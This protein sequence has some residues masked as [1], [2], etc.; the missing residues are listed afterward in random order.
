[1]SHTLHDAS[2][3]DGT[4]SRFRRALPGVTLMVLAPL[5]AEVLPGA[6]RLSAIFVLPIEIVIWGGGAVMIRE[7]VRRWRLGWLNL[8]LLAAAL[9]V[10]EEWLIQQTSLAPVVI[11][12][13]GVEYARAWDVNWVYF[14]WALIYEC[15]FVVV[16]PIGLAELI[17][18]R[19]RQEG[20]L[21]GAGAGIIA[22]LFLPACSLAWFSWTQIARTKVFHLEAYHPPLAHL[23]VGAAAMIVLIALAL[24][25]TRRRLARAP[26]GIRPPP[27]AALFV[28]SGALAVVIFGLEALAFGIAPTF[29]PAAAAAI[30]VGLIALVV[31]LPPRFRAH[32]TWGLWHELG[33][34]YGAIITNMAVFFVAFLGE[35][36][37]LDFYGKVVMDGIA[38]ALMIGFALRLRATGAA[39]P[40]SAA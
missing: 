5:V 33:A 14:L 12:L 29:P 39:I 25:P 36:T 9:S 7:A 40:W 26:Q 19:R 1:M 10:A 23:A 31:V 27:P 4:E 37:A 22:L 38:A 34:L 18:R 32:P 16:I 6:T 17:F 11:K 8:L 28:L 13:K 15:L 30:G 2:L 24:G 35:S 21:N 3:Q 20:W